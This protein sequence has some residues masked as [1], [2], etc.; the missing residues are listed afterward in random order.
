MSRLWHWKP[1]QPVICTKDIADAQSYTVGTT[2]APLNMG[3]WKA[4]CYDNGSSERNGD[5]VKALSLVGC[6]MA[7]GCMT[8]VL[9]F[10]LLVITNEPLEIGMWDFV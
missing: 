9:T 2:L 5:F 10:R 7:G 4:L 6:S 3:S 1:L 8:F